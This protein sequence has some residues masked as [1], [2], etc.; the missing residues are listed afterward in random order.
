MQ[1]EFINIAAH[2]LRTPVQP[3]IDLSQILLSKRGKIEN[4]IELIQ[5]EMQKGYSV[6][7]KIY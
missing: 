6:L 4:H 1:N 3:I 7:Q 2:E 5:T